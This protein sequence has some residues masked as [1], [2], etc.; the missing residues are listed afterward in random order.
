VRRLLAVAGKYADPSGDRQ[1]AADHD[2][3]LAE[4]YRR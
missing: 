1:V 2:A 4:A 3:V